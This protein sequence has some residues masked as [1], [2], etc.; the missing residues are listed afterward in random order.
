[1]VVYQS[2][3]RDVDCA[4][5]DGLES[6]DRCGWPWTDSLTALSIRALQHRRFSTWVQPRSLLC[7]RPGSRWICGGVWKAKCCV[8]ARTLLLESP[9][10][11][12]PK[13]TLGL[14]TFLPQLIIIHLL[15]EIVFLQ[16][17]GLIIDFYVFSCIW[18]QI[19]E[20]FLRC[21]F[22]RTIV[23]CVRHF[24][25]CVRLGRAKAFVWTAILDLNFRCPFGC[26]PFSM[27]IFHSN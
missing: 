6:W 26:C 20:C 5:R 22:A 14:L 2:T 7:T 24:D 23:F 4:K 16:T 10:A 9:A 3:G 18:F 21:K 12:P 25:H 19:F 13:S 17:T 11:K 8:Q 27:S 1:M 15:Y